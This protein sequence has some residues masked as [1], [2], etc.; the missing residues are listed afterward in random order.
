MAKSVKAFTLKIEQIEKSSKMKQTQHILHGKKNW[1]SGQ[2]LG[3][4]QSACWL[5]DACE[6]T[7]H[8]T[9][10]ISKHRDLWLRFF[11]TEFPEIIKLMG[12]GAWWYLPSWFLSKRTPFQK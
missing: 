5:V 4:K 2:Q 1:I 7:V 3:N 6:T 9:M 12:A 10:L 11:Y 8:D